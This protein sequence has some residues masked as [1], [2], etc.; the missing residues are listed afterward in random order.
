MDIR[1]DIANFSEYVPVQSA[2]GIA[3]EKGLSIEDVDKLD[4]GE[5]VWGPSPLVA[6][7]LSE[8]TGYQFYPDP[9]YLSLRK[10]IGKYVGVGY[11][12]VFVANGGDEIIDLLL[13]LMLNVGD[14]VI[15]TPPTFS[16]YKISAVLNR[17]IVLNV[18]RTK[19]WV[20]DTA[21]ILR[22]IDKTVKVVFIC[23][24]NNPTGTITPISEIEKILKSGV[25]VCVDEAYIEY[26]GQ[27]CV[28][29]LKKYE[30]LVILRTFS[31][32][33][34]IA[35]LRLGYSLASVNLVR[36]LMKI[37]QPYN[38]NFAAVIAGIAS[39]EDMSYRKRTIK[40]ITDE[41][42]MMYRKIAGLD[43]C[44]VIPSGGNFLFIEAEKEVLDG[45]LKKFKDTNIAVRTL[46]IN[47]ES[48]LRITIGKPAQNRKVL[49]I[50]N[51]DND[52]TQYDA[53]LFDM[54][55]VLVD[56]TQSYRI[57]I[58]K[59]ASFFLKRT[60]TNEEVMAIKGKV[61]MNNDWDATYALIGN[62]NIPYG[63][64][65]DYFQNIY[66][67]NKKTQGLIEKEDLLIS[68]KNLVSLKKKY[69]KMGIVT[70]RPRMEAEYVI[71]RFRLGKIFD[72][73]IAKEDSKRE[74]PFP[75][76]IIRAVNIL[77]SKTP[78]YIGDSPSDVVAANAADIPCLYIGRNPAAKKEFQSLLQLY[79]Y[80]I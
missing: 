51:T 77:K 19:D 78:V 47:G 35:G 4:A 72:I 56:V 55:G 70:G 7:R 79:R 62:D 61:G 43:V 41:R 60:V 16:S 33:A 36:Q 68:R 44:R 34:G 49:S 39:L 9:A 5:N 3:R 58:R 31:K 63:Q 65:K 45:A 54:D 25:L 57:A 23:N 75:D 28:P 22:N 59:T 48:A 37:K 14:K 73:L 42:E 13:R 6:K 32:W 15:D 66:L 80:L 71:K 74:K 52:R 29:L 67:G 24:P 27:S 1:N 11:N 17:G 26:G 53:L 69:G 18:P 2:E 8:F 10:K 38:V 64:V 46:S 21:A 40:K 20:I 50:L 30:N 76:P 12:R